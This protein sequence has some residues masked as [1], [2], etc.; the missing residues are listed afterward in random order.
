M[1]GMRLD[2]PSPWSQVTAT[3]LGVMTVS[4]VVQIAG[5]IGI[6]SSQLLRAAWWAA[7]AAAT[8]L[9]LCRMRSILAWRAPPIDRIALLPLATLVVAMAINL[10]VAIAPS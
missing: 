2:L 9:L 3:L 8:T 1:Y 10:L 4:L 5:I 6:A 7:L